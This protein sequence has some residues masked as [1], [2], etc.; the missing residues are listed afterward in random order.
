MEFR[1]TSSRLLVIGFVPAVTFFWGK[2]LPH[3][4][5][6]L[7]LGR[8][9]RITYLLCLLL[10]KSLSWI[11]QITTIHTP[12]ISLEPRF[13]SELSWLYWVPLKLVQWCRGMA[14]R[15]HW[16]SSFFTVTGSWISLWRRQIRGFSSYWLVSPRQCSVS[17]G[18]FPFGF[19]YMT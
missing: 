18:F 3:T 4:P 7:P 5:R 15:V 11:I 2:T 14:V 9:S 6:I 10:R 16:I 1:K 12:S 13:L 17:L 8:H 19:M